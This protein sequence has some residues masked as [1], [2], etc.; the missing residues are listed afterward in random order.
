MIQPFSEAP[1][2][3]LTVESGGRGTQ[4]RTSLRATAHQSMVLGKGLGIH[5]P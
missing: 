1:S 2:S 3:S 5:S 4:S